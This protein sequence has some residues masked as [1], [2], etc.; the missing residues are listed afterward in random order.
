MINYNFED[1]G[2]LIVQ[3]KKV[4]CEVSDYITAFQENIKEWCE[5]QFMIDD[6][7]VKIHK[8]RDFSIEVPEEFMLSGKELFL[9]EEAFGVCFLFTTTVIPS[10]KIQYC[11]RRKELISKRREIP[12]VVNNNF[13]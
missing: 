1:L 2:K 9:I 13:L 7:N 10:N 8:S 6:V 5:E 12:S 11:F 3:N 4:A